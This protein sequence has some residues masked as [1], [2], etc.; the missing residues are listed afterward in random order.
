[1]QYNNSMRDQAERYLKEVI[2]DFPNLILNSCKD[3]FAEYSGTIGFRANYDDLEEIEDEFEV[4]IILPLN[5][6]EILPSA[7]ETGQRIPI[8]EENHINSD[9]SMCLGAPLQVLQK[10][11][12]EPTLSNFIRNLLIPFLYAISFKEKHGYM[13]FGELSHGPIGIFEYY[14]ELFEIESELGVLELLKL[15]VEDNYRGHYTCPCGSASRLRDCHGPLILEI[16]TLQSRDRFF[17]DFLYCHEVYKD[18]GNELPKEFWTKRIKD[19]INKTNS[20]SK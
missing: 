6:A 8:K 3:G 12:S 9:G 15:I 2:E 16:K 11:R 13:P 20:T 18:S 4:N 1:M 14:K 19:Y 5:N 17:D 7:K 10:L